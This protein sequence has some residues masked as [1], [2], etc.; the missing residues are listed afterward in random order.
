MRRLLTFAYKR[1]LATEQFF[2]SV[3]QK[4]HFYLDKDLWS[5]KVPPTVMQYVLY[6]IIFSKNEVEK[7]HV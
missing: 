6:L 4:L 7:E 1:E 2:L 5:R 3:Y